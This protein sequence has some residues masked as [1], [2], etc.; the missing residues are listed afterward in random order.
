MSRKVNKKSP[1][2]VGA[3][4]GQ[5]RASNPYQGVSEAPTS[6]TRISRYKYMIINNHN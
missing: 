3:V 6:H 4:N 2:Q 1:S 5:T